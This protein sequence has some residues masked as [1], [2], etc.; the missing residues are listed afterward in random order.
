[1]DL[2]IPESTTGSTVQSLRNL[3][4]VNLPF[5]WRAMLNGLH[6]LIVALNQLSGECAQLTEQSAG[7]EEW[8]RGRG[9][10]DWQNLIHE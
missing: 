7:T 8:R 4:M 5:V 6:L 3:A 9:Y 10:L 2:F 1:M